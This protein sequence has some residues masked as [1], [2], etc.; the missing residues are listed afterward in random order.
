MKFCPKLLLIV[1]LNVAAG[2]GGDDGSS[3]SDTSGAGDAGTESDVGTGAD[4]AEV[5]ASEDTDGPGCTEIAE[6]RWVATG[7]CVGMRM[8]ADLSVADDG[9][10]FTLDDW[11]MA[12]SVPEGG[13]VTDDQVA[14]DGDDW[15]GCTGTLSADGRSIEASCPSAGGVPSCTFTMQAE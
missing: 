13:T 8:T 10:S 6:G 9:C 12:M 3:P 7:E 4:V 14:F 5:S 11:N 1:C 2:C 15:S